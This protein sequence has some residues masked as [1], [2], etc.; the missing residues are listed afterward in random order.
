MQ[1]RTTDIF[2]Q[3]FRFISICLILFGFGLPFLNQP[4]HWDETAYIDGVRTI[5][6]VGGFPFV[7]FWSYKPPLHFELGALSWLVMGIGRWQLRVLST[8][9]LAALATVMVWLV[10]S[11][12]IYLSRSIKL[13]I[14]QRVFSW[15]L[16]GALLT[17]PV[18][19]GQAWL[20]QPELLLVLLWLSAAYLYITRKFGWYWV[21]ASLLVLTKES[22]VIYL[23]AI[24][25]HALVAGI[26]CRDS[27][28]LMGKRILFVASPLVWFFVWM[29]G[30]KLV[31][32]WWLWPHNLEFFSTT[33]PY[34]AP[35]ALKLQALF[36]EANQWLL[37][38]LAGVSSWL[39]LRR[40]ASQESQRLQS[41]IS[42]VGL[43]LFGALLQI[44][45][46]GFG[47]FIPRYVIGLYP[48]LLFLVAVGYWL[49]G[50]CNRWTAFAGQVVVAALIFCQVAYLVASL[51][52]PMLSW[53]LD[54]DLRYREAT[55]QY[56]SLY[57]WWQAEYAS[58]T[59]VGDWLAWTYFIDPLYGYVQQPAQVVQF[60]DCAAA[61]STARPYLM[62]TGIGATTEENER[63]I[64]CAQEHNLVVLAEFG[65]IVVY[66]AKDEK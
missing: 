14:D 27:L 55:R 58:H 65:P 5:F 63:I 40:V 48:A 52:Q 17:N 15:L 33:K 26:V 21:M 59:L 31:L 9:E 20:Y 41:V 53:S 34:A 18:V 6:S 45:F 62:A 19:V 30:N 25:G 47:A 46:V 28:L 4:A 56:Q 43:L 38:A 42:F 10:Q 3:F 39:I 32:S 1:L 11:V 12:F 13:S 51:K 37:T 60:V 50:S 49:L 57:S 54:Q 36:I 66:T 2:S 64:N 61:I 7:E 22:G 23:A 44:I 24:I 8:L 16:V 29:I 35:L